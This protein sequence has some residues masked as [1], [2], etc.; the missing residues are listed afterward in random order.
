MTQT[1]CSCKHDKILHA[2]LMEDKLCMVVGCM[3]W[4]FDVAKKPKKIVQTSDQA[5][6]RWKKL[7]EEESK[8]A[9]KRAKGGGNN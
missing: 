6:A 1:L 5:K 3:C 4:N 8:K 9:K 2:L 7:E